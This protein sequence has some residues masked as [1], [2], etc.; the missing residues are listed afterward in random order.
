MSLA[1]EKRPPR[2]RALLHDVAAPL[3]PDRLPFWV[4]ASP[5]GHGDGWYWIPKDTSRPTYLGRNV[6]H[7]LSTL[8][9]ARERAR[10]EQ[11]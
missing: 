10:D 2:D 9:R 7:A 3:E 11:S 6:H 1:V 5:T 4:I 8:L